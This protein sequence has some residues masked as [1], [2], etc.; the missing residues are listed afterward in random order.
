LALVIGTV[1]AQFFFLPS[2][3]DIASTNLSLPFAESVDLWLFLMILLF[4]IGV[5]S[6]AYPAF[7]V[8]AM[9][10]VVILRGE[11]ASSSKKRFMQAFLTFQF[12]LAF[13][14]MITSTMLILNGR[15][16]ANQDW[17]YDQEH[18][19]VIRLPESSDYPALRSA[20]LQIPHIEHMAGTKH[21]VGKS[22]GWVD[23]HIQGEAMEA[24][25]FDVSTTY[26][27]TM[28]LRLKTGRFLEEGDAGQ[29]IVVNEAFVDQRG[30]SDE[31]ALGQTVRLDSINYAITGIVHNF[32][33]DDFFDLI[34]PIFFRLTEEE[35]FG[36]FAVRTKPG[37]AVQTADALE[38]S[39]ARL[40]PDV[41]FDNFFFFQDT[42]FDE[43]YEESQGITNVFVFTALMA[44]LLSC[45][46]LFGLAAQNVAS[47]M[48]EIS[49]RKVLGA[50]VMQVTQ[51]VNRRFFMLLIIAAILASPLSFFIV[52]M[53]LGSIYVYH[54]PMGPAPFIIAYVLVFLTAALTISTQL[55]KVV[56]ANPAQELR[57]D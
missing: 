30:W 48:K 37:T 23:V 3:N 54:L 21:H 12:I 53:L 31:E 33:Y 26:D 28:G 7:Y 24:E 43:F 22:R 57:N 34:S 27:Q 5:V 51:L 46:G 15:Y 6:G 4:I 19:L 38:E 11:P 55:R 35:S 18:T 52:E 36:Y 41:E 49:I 47:R 40:H 8:A 2:F 16:Q 10:P 17:G 9:P 50:S 20:A 1:L 39:W 32:H 44:L 29:A 45:M 56:T 14:T 42:A 25:H 13:I